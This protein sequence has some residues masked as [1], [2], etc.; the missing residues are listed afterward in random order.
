MDRSIVVSPK[1]I[2][3]KLSFAT[4]IN[5]KRFAMKLIDNFGWDHKMA[6]GSGLLPG[7]PPPGIGQMISSGLVCQPFPPP[8]PDVWPKTKKKRPL[9]AE[10]NVGRKIR[11]LYRR[12]R[13]QWGGPRGGGIPT[14]VR[15]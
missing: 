6:S 9:S 10:K 7:S 15:P 11:R 14:T 3:Q 13:K 12:R 4:W 8:R 1:C 2:N 5:Q